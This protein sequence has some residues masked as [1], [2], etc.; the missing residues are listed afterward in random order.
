MDS[1]DYISR[2]PSPLI[3]KI[4]STYFSDV[5]IGAGGEVCGG[6][7]CTP[8]LYLQMFFQHL[9][10]KCLAVPQ[11]IMKPSVLAQPVRVF[12]C[13]I[14]HL[15]RILSKAVSTLKNPEHSAAAQFCFTR[16]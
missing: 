9:S 3:N 1:F 2:V 10:S 7:G 12:L 11:A 14:I 6:V 5:R 4:I 16:E 8:F 13:D 15:P